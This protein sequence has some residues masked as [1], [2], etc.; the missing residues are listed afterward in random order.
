[1][2]SFSTESAIIDQYRACESTSGMGLRLCE[3]SLGPVAQDG[4]R[5]HELGLFIPLLP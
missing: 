5:W 1:V 2:P 3:N 4:L